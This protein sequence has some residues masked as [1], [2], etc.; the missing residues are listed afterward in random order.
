MATP[1][2]RV[3]IVGTGFSGLGMAV[4]L[5]RSGER[6][7]LLL[8]KADEVGGTWRD[9]RYPGCA[10]DVPSRLYS[11]SFDQNPSWSREYA[12]APEIW[13]YLK[14]V[15]DRYALRDHVAFGAALTSAVYDE[16]SGRWHLAA[17][18]GR[19]WTSDALVLGVGGLHEPRRPD[20]AGLDT[21]AGPVLHTADWPAHD[22]LDGKRVA[23]VGTG[24]SVVQLVPELAPRARHTTVFQRTAAWTMPKHDRVWTPARQGRYRRWPALQRL[25][26]WRTYWELEARAPLF[27]RFPRL[28]KLA[29]Q[30]ALWSLRRAVPDP[31]TRDRLTPRYTM[32]CKRI[33]L[34]DD[35]WPTFARD[36]VSLVT[37][38]IARV[39]PDAVVTADGTRHEVDAIV[40][41]TGFTIGGSFFRIDLRGL[42]GRTLADAWD[43]GMHTH[44][45]ITV[46]GFPELYL[47]LG[48]NTALGHSSVV[49]MSELASHYVLRCLRRARQG[50]RVTTEVAQQ[51]F[52]EQVRRKSRHTVWAT[53]CHSWYLDRFGQNTTLW[54]GST[55][56]YWWRTR[57]VDDTAFAPV[58]AAAQPRETVDA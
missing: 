32:G 9:N 33:L 43:Q 18:D 41:G 55:I 35:Y 2:H 57:R 51:R 53:G 38:P 44:L 49:L 31:V 34:S 16:P 46:A 54:P 48:P 22:D 26:R 30:R 10:C 20:I 15:A 4:Q 1:H 11:F 5:A 29:Q 3:V 12:T 25:V 40:L 7:F 58:H 56:S 17:A 13:E 28:A 27:V 14:G 8:E 47:L 52:T 6:D 24:A 36:D 19:T 37:D 50:A 23:V 45:G 42:G 39:E 21:F